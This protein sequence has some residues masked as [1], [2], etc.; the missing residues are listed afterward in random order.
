MD[1][2]EIFFAIHTITSV[3]FMLYYI[4]SKVYYLYL[5]NRHYK[6]FL[7]EMYNYPWR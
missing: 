5:D 3:C 4:I 1:L 2:Y 7:G 6:N